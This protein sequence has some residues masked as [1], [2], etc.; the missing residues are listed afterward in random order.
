M[1]VLHVATVHH[2]IVL[3]AK[4]NYCSARL[5][6]YNVITKPC[7][8]MVVDVI[9]GVENSCV[10]MNWVFGELHKYLLVTCVGG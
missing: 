3:H 10:M 2:V 7:N 6:D 5:S 9:I 4:Y 8:K 1:A